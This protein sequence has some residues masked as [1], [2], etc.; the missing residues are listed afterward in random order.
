MKWI[1][2]FVIKQKPFRTSL[3]L[4]GVSLA[5]LLLPFG[6]KAFISSNLN[7]VYTPFWGIS[8]KLTGAFEVYEINR[9]LKR[10]ITGQMLELSTLRAHERENIRL[11]DLL[12]FKESVEY[13]LIPAEIVAVDPK[14]RQNAVIAEVASDA[15]VTPNLPVVNVEG[16]VGK[17]M[18]TMGD[19]V[20]IELLTSPDCRAAARDA[21]TRVLGI[22]RWDGGR[23]L[24]FDN[25]E[26]SDSVCMGDTVIT[27][28]LGGVFPENLPIGTIVSISRGKSP[29]FKSIYI[30]PFV[31]FRALDE[32]TILKR[33]EN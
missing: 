5:C 23:H 7:I 2:P 14:R 30:R 11:R 13:E 19:V 8:S 25:V 27:S 33:S 31:E 16:L 32:L 12:G 26:L 21:N 24:L 10:T 18:S 9:Q 1:S 17:T 20:T 28:G 4:A 29:F 15:V 22:V 6:V 3:I